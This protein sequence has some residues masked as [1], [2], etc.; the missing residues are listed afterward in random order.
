MPLVVLPPV[1]LLTCQVTAVLLVPLTAALNVCEPKVL[2]V[3]V[4]GMTET[5]TLGGTVPPPVEAPPPHPDKMLITRRKRK[6]ALQ[7]RIAHPPK[8]F[9]SALNLTWDPTRL[10]SRRLPWF[11]DVA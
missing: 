5:V 10:G 8:A 1:T 4:A 2:S 9:V 3:I 7:Q 6:T 11:L